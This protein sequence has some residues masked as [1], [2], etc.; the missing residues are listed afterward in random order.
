M[1]PGRRAEGLGVGAVHERRRVR[2]AGAAGALARARAA[3]AGRAARPG[4]APGPLGL[5]A[6]PARSV[7]PWK[8]PVS[9]TGSP[10]MAKSG[11]LGVA[12]TLAGVAREKTIP[13]CWAGRRRVTASKLT[14]PR[15]G[16][17][18]S[19]ISCGCAL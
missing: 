5:R 1:A 4:T 3:R 13:A 15:V 18:V 6:R 8:V 7:A 2:G 19:I 16:G 10:A 9:V 11:R 17:R 12:A 14:S